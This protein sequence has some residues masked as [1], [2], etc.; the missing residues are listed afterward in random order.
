MVFSFYN[1]LEAAE[2]LISKSA[3]KDFEFDFRFVL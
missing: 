3:A 2:K 1:Y